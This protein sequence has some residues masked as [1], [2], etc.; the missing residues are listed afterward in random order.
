[1]VI[2]N[3]IEK[4]SIVLSKNAKYL[5]NVLQNVNNDLIQYVW[6]YGLTVAKL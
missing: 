6:I 3:C 5:F 2:I 4:R 1:M